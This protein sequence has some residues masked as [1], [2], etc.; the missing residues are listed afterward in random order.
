MSLA[1][2]AVDVAAL[3]A[4]CRAA[5]A[6]ILAIYTAPAPLDVQFKA[7]AS[8]LTAADQAAHTLICAALARLTPAIP[9]VS[10][11]SS[12][13]E[14]AERQQ[15][16]RYWLIDPLDGTK[17]FLAKN[18][19]FTV[20]IALIEQGRSVWGMVY[21]PVL[22]RL[23]YG[24]LGVGAWQQAAGQVAQAIACQPALAPWRVVGSRHHCSPETH[25]F[26]RPFGAISWQPR[27]SSLKICL[28]AQGEADLYPRLAPTCEWDTAAAQ[29]V[30]EGAG[31][32]LTTLAGEP[33]RYNKA[34]LLNPWFVAASGDWQ[35]WRLQ[36]SPPA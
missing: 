32:C 28:I 25:E 22:D 33:L 12:A 9:C 24:G 19:D 4:I 3:A 23:W 36:A 10:E 14:L 13:D 29:A 1:P 15:W 11:E 16:A 17:E 8:P 30:L 7:D 35:A 2:F 31:G 27:G 6:A 21:A 20:N 26:L 34:D 18:G 5:G